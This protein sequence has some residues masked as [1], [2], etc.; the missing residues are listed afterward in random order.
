MA[1]S[2]GMANSLES[3]LDDAV[4]KGLVGCALSVRRG[5]QEVAV[6]ARGKADRKE[7]LPLDP[8]AQ[9]RIA[10]ITKTFVAA[11]VL[12]LIEEGRFGL[13][14]PL[15]RWLP[16]RPFADRVTLRHVLT[17]TGGLPTY[18][19]YNL[20]DFPPADA[21]LP[22]TVFIDHAYERTPPTPPG[23]PFEYANV[24]SRVLG[25]IVELE[26]GEDLTRRMEMRLLEPLGLAD[27]LASGWRGSPPPRLAR[28]Y[29]H[30]DSVVRDVTHRV[31]PNYLWSGGDMVSTV[32][33]LTRWTRALFT[34]EVVGAALT[35]ALRTELVAG[36]FA[37]SSMSHHGLGVMVFSHGERRLF[38]HRGSTPGFVGIVGYDPGEDVAVA[39]QSNSYAADALSIF[40]GE[41][42]TILF[43]ALRVA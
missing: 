39:V 31:P 7:V 21:D 27:T 4:G 29:L 16:E 10:S 40:R 13:D 24:G 19:L 6:L 11:L 26:T 43:E 34:G 15:A 36:V 41:V 25:H 20:D 37:G 14:E 42:E 33:D 8:D 9:F 5:S 12:Q 22:R 1:L 2:N 23:G 18:S 32:S 28:G 3:I 30:E 38:G 35:E 17:H